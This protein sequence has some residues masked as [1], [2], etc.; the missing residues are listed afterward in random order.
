MFDRL[1]CPFKSVVMIQQLQPKNDKNSGHQASRPQ[2]SHSNQTSHHDTTYYSI[3]QAQRAEKPVPLAAATLS[4]SSC[5]NHIIGYQ[6]LPTPRNVDPTSN[7]FY[8]NSKPSTVAPQQESQFSTN[9]INSKHQILPQ[10]E[11]RASGVLNNPAHN[12]TPAASLHSTLGQISGSKKDNSCAAHDMRLDAAGLTV[13]T[14]N[15]SKTSQVQDQI[16]QFKFSNN[17]PKN[18]VQGLLGNPSDVIMPLSTQ[19]NTIVPQSVDPSIPQLTEDS[20]QIPNLNGV[21]V[22]SPG[23]SLQSQVDSGRSAT[24]SQGLPS[25]SEP[26]RLVPV[27]TNKTPKDV[28]SNE[29][30]TSMLKN[31]PMS[32]NDTSV[33]IVEEDSMAKLQSLKEM[34]KTNHLLEPVVNQHISKRPAKPKLVGSLKKR[35]ISIMGDSSF[36]ELVCFLIQ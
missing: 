21:Q 18:S 4:N 8:N 24:M 25:V 11:Y 22:L 26:P 7:E 15:I 5:S 17:S 27:E 23:Q 31:V 2:E 36:W 9:T 10:N 32:D 34:P 20:Q 30:Q 14:S 29:S 3:E 6:G 19:N 35:I 28:N 12:I 13:S 1:K 16:P 33:T